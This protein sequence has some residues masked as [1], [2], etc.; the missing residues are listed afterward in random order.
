MNDVEAHGP[1]DVIVIEFPENQSGSNTAKE[2]QNL[3]DRGTIHLYDVMVVHK[4]A[5]GSCSEVDLTSI[6]SSNS[7]LTE[8]QAFSG[9]RSGLLG[10]D[11]VESAA[12]ILEPETTAAVVVYENAWAVPFVAAARSEGAE[13]VASTR[14]SAQEIMDELDEMDA[15]SE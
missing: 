8:W 1:I 7:A 4:E 5:N 10:M 11:D 6:D 9:A 14:I 3:V 2:V 13:M 12:A 15:E